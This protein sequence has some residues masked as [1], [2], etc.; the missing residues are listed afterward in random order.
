M[1]LNHLSDTG[2]QTY[3]SELRAQS[4]ATRFVKQFTGQSMSVVTTYS[5]SNLILSLYF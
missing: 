3:S 4:V 1:D 2:W 5:N